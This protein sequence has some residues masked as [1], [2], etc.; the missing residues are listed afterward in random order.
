MTEVHLSPVHAMPSGLC[1]DAAGD[2]TALI[3]R[4]ARS[5][6]QALGEMFAAWGPVFLG[7]A[8]RM[9]GDHQEAA[10]IVHDTFDR[11]WRRAADYDPHK[12]PPFVWA[13][14][15]LRDLC[16]ERIRRKPRNQPPQTE[17]ATPRGIVNEDP[18]V[19]PLDD[20]RRLRTALDSLSAEERECL[21]TAVFLGYARSGGRTPTE[22]PSLT[23]KACLRRA[24]DL[25]RNQ[26]SRYEL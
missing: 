24:L 6:R 12:S 26:L 14:T 4:M 17:P 22:S 15:I 1:E 8:R 20:W 23:V 2:A 19:M 11:I 5:D 18:G 10:K 25:V 13:F 21:E 7:I 3:R 16:I 9:L